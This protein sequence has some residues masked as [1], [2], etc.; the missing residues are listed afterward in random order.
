MR[1]HWEWVRNG[2]YHGF[3]DGQCLA[4]VES[5]IGTSGTREGWLVWLPHQQTEPL[6][7]YPSLDE[8]KDAAQAAFGFL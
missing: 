4:Q 6:G 8:G 3:A 7:Q 5:V 1:L 2:V